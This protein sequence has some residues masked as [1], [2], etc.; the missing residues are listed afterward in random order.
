MKKCRYC[1][2]DLSYDLFAKNKSTKDGLSYYCKKCC[3]KKT[4]E[5]RAREKTINPITGKTEYKKKYN[6]YPVN[7]KEYLRNVFLKR[8]YNITLKLYN[9]MLIEQDNKCAICARHSDELPKSLDVDHDHITGKV[10]GLLCG[11]CNMGIGYFQDNI[12]LINKASA[13]I[14]NHNYCLNN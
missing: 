4:K 14:K 7:S 8:K 12:N 1:K 6:E 13:Y 9:Q 3:V 10:R 5:S 11:K 2:I